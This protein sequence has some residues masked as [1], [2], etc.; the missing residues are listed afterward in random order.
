M[1]PHVPPFAS[2]LPPLVTRP[3]DIP[4]QI[5]AETV[6]PAV[7]HRQ[8]HAPLAE[9]QFQVHDAKALSEPAAVVG[10]AT[11][12]EAKAQPQP[13]TPQSIDVKTLLR[14]TLGLRGAMIVR[15]ILGQP[16]GLREFE[17]P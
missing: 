12:S 11:L 6:A 1:L 8:I 10:S 17:F 14:S 7:E 2:P 9:S 13:A 15:E 16:R 3:P 5:P 4:P